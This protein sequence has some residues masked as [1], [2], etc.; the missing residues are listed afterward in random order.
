M[1]RSELKKGAFLSS[2]DKQ[3]Y[4]LLTY[5]DDVDVN[6]KLMAREGFNNNKQ[7][8]TLHGGKTPYEAMKSLV[9]QLEKHPIGNNVLH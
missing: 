7:P 3:F 4:Q 8:H 9:M 2:F 1:E 6:E 5:K